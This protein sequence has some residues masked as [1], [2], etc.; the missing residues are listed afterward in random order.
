ML[1]SPPSPESKTNGSVIHIYVNPFSF[2]LYYTLDCFIIPEM[3]FTII[4][5]EVKMGKQKKIKTAV[6]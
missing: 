6:K 4:L 1:V 3:S 5:Q 2:V